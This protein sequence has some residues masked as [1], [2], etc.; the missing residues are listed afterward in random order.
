MNDET[1]TRFIKYN[2]ILSQLKSLGM[3]RVFSNNLGDALGIAPALVRKDFSRFNLPGNKRGGYEIDT[4]SEMLDELLCGRNL[5]NMIIIGCGHIAKALINHGDF[6]KDGGKIVAGFDIFPHDE[7]F[8]NI[9]IYKNEILPT[10]VKEHNIKIAILTVPEDAAAVMY[11]KL[12]ALDIKGVLN[13]T[14][15]ELKSCESC[16]VNNVNI[17]LEIKKL[18]YMVKSTFNQ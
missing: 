4:L 2:R 3:A 15:V 10:Y 16:I 12:L 9:P 14:P 8:K 13:F 6:T 7:K 18:T 17:G 5:E 1:V 11:E